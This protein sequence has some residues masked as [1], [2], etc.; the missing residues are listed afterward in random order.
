MKENNDLIEF[1]QRNDKILES[2]YIFS[3]EMMNDK[4]SLKIYS[5]NTGDKELHLKCQADH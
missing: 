1:K 2:K 5:I 4:L 3:T